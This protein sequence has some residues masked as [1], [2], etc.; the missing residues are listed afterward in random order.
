MLTKRAFGRGPSSYSGINITDLPIL[1]HFEGEMSPSY[2]RVNIITQKYL[3]D[4]WNGTLTGNVAYNRS[5][6]A[7]Q[8]TIQYK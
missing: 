4:K 7:I 3:V 2:D 8:I 5:S 6:P 1:G